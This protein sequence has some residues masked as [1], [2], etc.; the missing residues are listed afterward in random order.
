MQSEDVPDS[1]C[2]AFFAKIAAEVMGSLDA[3]SFLRSNL[4]AEADVDG[5]ELSEEAA[6][7]D[8][9]SDANDV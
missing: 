5:P 4:S 3:G 2:K 1:V 6:E 7:K 9:T 8:D